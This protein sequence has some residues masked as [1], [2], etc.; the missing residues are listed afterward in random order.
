MAAP[1]PVG[2]S[3]PRRR[4]RH[5]DDRPKATRT[6]R[7]NQ[8]KSTPAGVRGR[9]EDPEHDQQT[10]DTSGA[11]V[12]PPRRAALDSGALHGTPAPRVRPAWRRGPGRPSRRGALAEPGDDVARRSLALVAPPPW[13]PSTVRPGDAG[14]HGRASSSGTTSAMT[15]YTTRARPPVNTI[16]RAHRIRTS[17]GSAS[18]SSARP[19]A[20]PAIR[21]SPV[22]GRV[23]RPSSSL[24]RGPG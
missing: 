2:S 11:A 8:S 24:L 16:R 12:S 22:T 13:C 7:P 6:A 1:L 9:E 5:Q 18:H 20:T 19:P 14:G 3:L 17:A 15:M 10:A 21:R 4:T 23:D